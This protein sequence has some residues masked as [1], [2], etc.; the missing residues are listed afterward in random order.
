MA[1]HK[2]LFQNRFTHLH[3]LHV[4]GTDQNFTFMF[5]WVPGNQSCFKYDPDKTLTDD[6]T[7][8]DNAKGCKVE[9]VCL[10]FL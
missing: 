7:S 1:V 10:F 2:E 8:D 6:N 3:K 5:L 4:H 9:N